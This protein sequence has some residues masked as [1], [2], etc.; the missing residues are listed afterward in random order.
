MEKVYMMLYRPSTRQAPDISGLHNSYCSCSEMNIICAMAKYI[1]S[2]VN[3]FEHLR[4]GLCCQTIF[5]SI[6][7]SSDIVHQT[8]VWKSVRQLNSKLNYIFLCVN[9]QWSTS[10][11][12]QTDR[13]DLLNNCLH[14]WTASSPYS[15]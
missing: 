9:G 10:Y 5:Q 15:L 11:K 13:R 7:L 1:S 2:F 8:H 3:G 4:F 14:I 12:C 6:G